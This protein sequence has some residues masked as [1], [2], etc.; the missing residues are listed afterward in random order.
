M[1]SK[2]VRVMSKEEDEFF[3]GVTIENGEVPDTK[4]F[5][6]GDEVSV[7]HIG[8]FTFRTDSIGVKIVLGL[9]IAA[10]AAFLLFIALPVALIILGVLLVIWFILSFF[11]KK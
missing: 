10:I 11:G 7:I 9:I 3:D 4:F 2:S 6:T 5:E 1:E 8:N